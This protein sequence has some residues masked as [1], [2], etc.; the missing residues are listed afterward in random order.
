MCRE[1]ERVGQVRGT[2]RGD[3]GA[4]PA[5]PGDAGRSLHAPVRRDAGAAVCAGQGPVRLH[6]QDIQRRGGLDRARHW[7]QLHGRRILQHDPARC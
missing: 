3:E 2:R 4:Q 5:R 1:R 6:G 7:A